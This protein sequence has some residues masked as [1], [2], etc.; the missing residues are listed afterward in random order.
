[1]T[2]TETLAAVRRLAPAIAGRAAEI[3]AE[4]RLPRDLL[5]DLIGAGAFRV[6]LPTSHGGAGADLP[7]AMRIFEALATADASTA[8]TVMI[9]SGA[10]FDLAG[11]PRA[12]F[13][14]LFPPDEDVIIAGALSPSGSIAAADGGYR[15]Q[16][17]WGFVSG[18]EHATWV[19]GNCVEGI[20][21][22]HPQMRGA[23]FSPAE[24]E[25]EDT[26]RVVGLRG[27]GSH[28]VNVNDVVVPRERTFALFVDEPCLDEPILRV[29]PPTLYSPCVAAAAI[30]IAQGALDDIVA[31]AEQKMPFLADLSLAAT[32]SFQID[33]ATADT[34]LRA[35]RAL[36]YETAESTWATAVTGGEPLTLD[37]RAR[38][39]ATAVWATERATDVVGTAYRSGGSS[40]IYDDSPLQRRLRD[41]H[42]ITQHF[43]VKH[44]TLTTAGAILAGQDPQVMVF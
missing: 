42:A 36:L 15:V 38:V 41:I 25:I 23:V 11:L 19:W 10:W 17:R 34:E 12:T 18:C 3:E 13:D 6:L 37:Q 35:A 7:S 16:G 30:G 33:L 24:I 14:A 28:H 29:P 9:G 27:T 20:V 26:W 44:D 40:S 31:I 4:R 5:D 21:D 1:M 22:G 32:P 2:P 39:R 8:W 43:L